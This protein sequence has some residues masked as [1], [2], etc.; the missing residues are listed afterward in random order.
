MKLF[1]LITLI[2]F[3]YA[4]AIEYSCPNEYYSL[5][6]ICH[7]GNIYFS[8]GLCLLNKDKNI[9]EYNQ[10]YGNSN[11]NSPCPIDW[12]TL[13]WGYQKIFNN[14]LTLCSCKLKQD[15]SIQFYQIGNCGENS[16]EFNSKILSF[17]N[18]NHFLYIFTC[19][20][21]N[22]SNNSPNLITTTTIFNSTSIQLNHT[23]TSFNCLNSS[24]NI[25][26]WNYGSDICPFGFYGNYCQYKDYCY[27]NVCGG[28][29]ECE[30]TDNK[31]TGYNCICKEGYK[32][33]GTECEIDTCY[34]KNFKIDCGS[35]KCNLTSNHF[36]ENGI[37]YNILYY[38]YCD[39]GFTL[40]NKII[41][42]E[43]MKFCQKI[44]ECSNSTMCGTANCK[45]DGDE[46]K[47]VCLNEKTHLFISENGNVS[48]VDNPD[49]SKWK[50]PVSI[51]VSVIGLL[52]IFCI[53]M[54]IYIKFFKYKKSKTITTT[55]TT[56]NNN[57]Y[58]DDNSLDSQPL[59]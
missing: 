59:L 28:N 34:I 13:S 48:C 56:N 21:N 49:S 33:N 47:C 14:S 25:F 43:I 52:F 8:S 3:N 32:F 29:G 7:K 50:I 54:F 2:I 45:K 24:I 6:N 58:E 30:N 53:S 36:T 42:N 41:G 55:T 16:I 26:T 1:I 20:P 22:S 9:K 44:G 5:S 27:L 17:T 39:E 37:D 38:C 40:Q 57:Y 19:S 31:G 23:S 4:T 12:I 35:A 18:E 10:F 15:N 11:I 46:D 51:M